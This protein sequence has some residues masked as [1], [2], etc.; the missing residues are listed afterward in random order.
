MGDFGVIWPDRKAERIENKLLCTVEAHVCP[1]A[2]QVTADDT[3]QKLLCEIVYAIL[4][5]LHVDHWHVSQQIRIKISSVRMQLFNHLGAHVWSLPCAC[6]PPA[7]H[8]VVCTAAVVEIA[9]VGAIKNLLFQALVHL[10]VY[11]TC[12]SSRG[13]P[14]S[15]LR[16]ILCEDLT[17]VLGAF[18][19][20]IESL[21]EMNVAFESG[22]FVGRRVFGEAGHGRMEQLPCRPAQFLL[23]SLVA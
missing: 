21:E 22:A 18:A 6:T 4:R 20:G 10:V 7:L 14:R 23:G 17:K 3:Q 5:Y 16:R 15:D 13:I 12:P 11:M 1:F 8:F 9:N 2:E 19:A